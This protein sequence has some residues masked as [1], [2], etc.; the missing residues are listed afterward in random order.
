MKQLLL[1]VRTKDEIELESVKGA[2]NIPL[3]ELQDRLLE[4]DKDC[5]I[6]AFCRSGRRSELAAN[7]LKKEGF[8]AKNIGGYDEARLH[9][10]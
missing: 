3:S 7:I 9:N 2:I 10:N 6:L 4:L 1:D 8:K 5:E